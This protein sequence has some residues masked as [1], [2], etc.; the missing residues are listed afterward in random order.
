MF[1]PL[2]SWILSTSSSSSSSSSSEEEHDPENLDT[3]NDESDY[4]NF[5]TDNVEDQIDDVDDENIDD[6]IP[7]GLAIS[8]ASPAVTVALPAPTD[9]T[10]ISTTSKESRSKRQHNK[11][12]GGVRQYQRIWTKQ[13][14]IEL[15][16]GYLDYIKQQGR[17][18]TTLQSDVASFYDQVTPKFRA[19]FNKN[20]IVEK[21]RR[22]KRKH[23]MVL[24]KAKEVQVSFKSSHEQAVFEI[25]RK[26]WGNDTDHDVLDVDESRPVPDS[27]DL[28]DNI[29]MKAEH[30][31]NCEET[32]K[33]VPKRPRLAADNGDATS[34]IHGF[35]EE[36]MRSCFSPLLKELL[37]DAPVE[38]LDVL[39]MLLSTEEERDEQRLKRRILELEVYLNRLELLQGQ[40]KARLEDLRSS[41]G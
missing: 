31:D 8:D 7:I 32:D 15:L 13:D 19:D 20:Q 38:P 12:S 34:S 22:L 35:I 28:I 33:R 11:Y 2:V 14:E 36:T 6:T 9:Y 16:K 21:L 26:I 30:V 39:P 18:T 40:I 3:S 17:T 10:N 41:L 24:D 1:S 23:K 25:S 4:E 5:Q 37:D 29:K 27:P